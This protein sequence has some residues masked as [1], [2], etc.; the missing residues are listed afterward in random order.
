MTDYRIELSE[1]EMKALF[2]AFDVNGDGQISYNEFAR[3]MRGPMNKFRRGLVLKAFNKLDRDGS[4]TINVQDLS[5]WY[6]PSNH[7]DVRSGKK[8]EEDI[9]QDF[10]ETFETH[11]NVLSGK[12]RDSEVTLEEFEE[13]YANVGASVDDD[14]YFEV[15]IT[16][17][18]RL[19]DPPPPKPA[20]SN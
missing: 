9:L 5:G 18:W 7:P 4:G 2:G 3:A 14:L 1:Q 12:A 16:N 11:H 20:W 8:T 10:L 19:N 13:Y 15:M 6:N 17:A